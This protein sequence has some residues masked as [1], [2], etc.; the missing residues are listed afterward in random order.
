MLQTPPPILRRDGAHVA[1]RRCAPAIL[2]LSRSHARSASAAPDLALT[3]TQAR[4]LIASLCGLH[5]I[6][7]DQSQVAQRLPPPIKLGAVMAFL[8]T[9]GIEA[10]AL[11]PRRLVDALRPGSLLQVGPLMRIGVGASL[12]NP[13]GAPTPLLLSCETPSLCRRD[14]RNLTYAWVSSAATAHREPPVVH[15]GC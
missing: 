2:P 10:R 8:G 7:M 9:L 4:L 14:G 11:Q 6:P 3:L 13:D 5:R 1:A 15:P 12:A